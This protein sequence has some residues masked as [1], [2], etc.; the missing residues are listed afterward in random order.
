MLKPFRIRELLHDD[1]D[2]YSASQSDQDE[3]LLSGNDTRIR[4]GI[5]QLTST[6]YDETVTRNPAARLSYVDEDDGEHITV[7]LL[8]YKLM[9][10]LGVKVKELTGNRI[11]GWIF[12]RTCPASG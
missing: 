11:L 6:E 8:S 2:L 10:Y 7:R 12:A 4:D 9:I 3:G 5:V 1:D